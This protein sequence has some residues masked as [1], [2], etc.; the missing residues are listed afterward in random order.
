MHNYTTIFELLALGVKQNKLFETIQ[1][2]DQHKDED[3]KA[4][5][6][7]ELASTQIEYTLLKNTIDKN[8]HSKH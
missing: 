3:I 4:W 6:I 8:E 7:A 2:H 5:E 1:L